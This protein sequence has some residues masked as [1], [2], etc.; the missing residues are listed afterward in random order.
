MITITTNIDSVRIDLADY[1]AQIPRAMVRAMNRAIGSGRTAIVREM[2]RDTGLKSKDVRDAIVL[3]EASLNRPVASISAPLK[4]LPL[5]KFN[6]R[7]PEP[8]RGRGRGVSY[9]L[10]GARGRSVI[11]NAFIATMGSGHR[12]VFVRVP[13]GNRRGPAPNRSQLPIRELF[14]PS[15]GKVFNKFKPLGVQRVEA[16]FKTNFDHELVF[17]G[18]VGRPVPPEADGGPA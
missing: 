15:L 11:R 17:A 14:G 16:S 8:S 3:R 9:N 5:F 18:A 12:G 7:G 13:G 10:P 4:R 2:A 1:A 6:A